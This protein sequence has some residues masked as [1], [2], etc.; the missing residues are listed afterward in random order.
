LGLAAGVW[1]GLDHRKESIAD[2]RFRLIQEA[3]P[4]RPFEARLAGLDYASVGTRAGLSRNFRQ[5]LREIEKR[6][7]HEPSPDGS[8]VR[9]LASLIGEL[10]P[11]TRLG[12]VI[13]DLEQATS[14]PG[15]GAHL[16]SDL[17]AAYLESASRGATWNY[18]RALEAALRAVQIDGDLPEARFN[19]ALALERNFLVDKARSAWEEVENSADDE[20]WKTEAAAHRKRLEHPTRIDAWSQRTGEL[21]TAALTGNRE[22]LRSIVKEFPFRARLHAENELLPAWAKAHAAGRDEEAA[23]KF[24]EASAVGAVL[25]EV[26][27]EHMVEDSTAALSR[28]LQSGDGLAAVAAAFGEYQQ[29]AR[30]CL[31]NQGA[32]GEALLIRARTVF[33]ALHSP[34]SAWADYQ[35]GVCAYQRYERRT[36]IDSLRK[37]LTGTNIDRYPSLQG[38]AWWMIG[39]S[40]MGLGEPEA[41]SEAYQAGLPFFEK[42]NALPEIAGLDQ[43]L[44]EAA[45]FVGDRRQAWVHLHRGLGIT[46]EDGDPRRLYTGLD[47]TADTAAKERLLNVALL[48]REEVAKASLRNPDAPG[49]THAFLRQAEAAFQ[50]GH[51]KEVLRYLNQAKG[52]CARIEDRDERR[53]READI[54]LAEGRLLALDQPV[55]AVTLLNQALEIYEAIGNRYPIVQAY[56]A[57]AQA[58]IDSGNPA[59]AEADLVSGIGEFERQRGEIKNEELRIVHFDQARQLFDLLIDLRAN[60]PDAAEAAFN[61]AEQQ[62]ARVLLDRVRTDRWAQPLSL[63]E[64]LRGLPEGISLVTYASLPERLL[65]WVLRRDI[66]PAMISVPISAHR[67]DKLVTACRRGIQ[68][69]APE[70]D[71]EV[72]LA[73]LH[74]VILKPVLSRI[75]AGDRIV[76]VPDKSLHLVPFAALYS[77]ETERFLVEDHATV[78][79]PSASLYAEAM[80]RPEMVEAQ[81]SLLVVSDPSFDRGLFPTLVSLSGAAEEGEEIAKLFPGRNLVLNGKEGTKKAFLREAARW[82]LLHLGMHALLN[83]DHPHLSRL[84]LAPVAPGDSGTLTAA[85]IQALPLSRTRL[86]FLASCRSGGGATSSEGVLSLARSFLAAGVPE[87]VSS[88]W[89]LDDEAGVMLVTDFYRRLLVDAQVA[90][91]LRETQLA[92]FQAH[93]PIKDWS[94]LQVLG[95]AIPWLPRTNSTGDENHGLSTASPLHRPLRHHSRERHLPAPE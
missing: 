9:A 91:A 81:P 65:I 72:S 88:L 51:E 83:P 80:D 7:V 53:S 16:W 47:K 15:A 17:S 3:G 70:K 31:D 22:A 84:L 78:V 49:L 61:A 66:E 76:F 6:V 92:A 57:R 4:V 32:A 41:A 73:S 40:H 89:D 77:R 36:A 94:A 43:L 63:N 54:L 69:E 50:A 13:A 85:E 90:M 20:G 25:A 42:T 39:L 95:R 27:G 44:S 64:V 79:S 67:L 10:D 46:V 24:Q 18:P 68:I 1:A 74:E 19:R 23:S 75:P 12:P 59:A 37:I 26:S 48:F 82:P 8:G 5:I 21:E 52:A 56:L 11:A 14:E 33:L 58:L 71:L 2:L 35:L 93:R 87:V 34:M 86:V 28:L 60:G 55:K 29:G 30:L 45:L 38:R 62:R